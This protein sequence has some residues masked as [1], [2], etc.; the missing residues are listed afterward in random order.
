MASIYMADSTS[1]VHNIYGLYRCHNIIT[2]LLIDIQD[3]LKNKQ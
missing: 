1:F 2:R 3:I